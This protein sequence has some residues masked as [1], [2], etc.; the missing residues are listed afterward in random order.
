M[1]TP[2]ANLLAEL[3][4]AQRAQMEQFAALMLRWNKKINVTAAK[5]ISDVLDH[6][7]DGIVASRL[8]P[9][10]AASL[11]DV[12]S[13]GGLPLIPMAIMR[14]DVAMLGIEPIAKK[15]AFIVS[16]SRELQ[17]S[18]VDVKQCRV[19]DLSPTSPFDVATSK[20]TFEMSRW[21]DIGLSLVG[22]R[23][24]VLGFGSEAASPAVLSDNDLIRFARGGSSY[25]ISRTWRSQ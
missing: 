5:S 2:A 1:V 21:L 6:C 4:A 20:A 14:P 3:S 11:V 8:I 17:L 24:A 12:G 13:G 25:W 7:V 9:P 16:S 10:G 23:G 18:N 15:W 19:E 22:S